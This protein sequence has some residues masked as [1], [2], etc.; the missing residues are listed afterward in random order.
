MKKNITMHCFILSRSKRL[1][2]K[3]TAC[4]KRAYAYSCDAT[5]PGHN[6]Q[7]NIMHVLAVR[8]CCLAERGGLAGLAKHRSRGIV[9]RYITSAAPVGRA[10]VA[11]HRP[12]EPH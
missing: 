1:T 10:P 9:D 3:R 8:A 6:L 12:L 7:A 5:C 4:R 11:V 2:I